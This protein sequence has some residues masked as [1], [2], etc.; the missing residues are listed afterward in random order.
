[1]ND[2][3]E[4]EGHEPAAHSMRE[5]VSSHNIRDSCPDG[6]SYG[7]NTWSRVLLVSP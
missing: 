7:Q 6:L 2:L 3:L 4:K 5:L 1:M